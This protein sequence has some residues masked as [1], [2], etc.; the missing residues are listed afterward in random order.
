VTA[1][2]FRDL[3]AG[4]EPLLLAN[5]WDRGSA[6][7]LAALGFRALA[8]TSS[9]H[10]RS[11][12]RLD[13]TVTRDEAIAH[14]RDLALAVDVPLSA[15]LEDGFAPDPEGVAETVRRAAAA[16]IAGCSIE[17]ST[18]GGDEPV[19]E[20]GHAVERVAAAV[21]AAR[22]AGAD[23]VLTARAENHLYGR[24]DLDDTI[25]RLRAYRAAGADVVYAPGV[26]AADDIRAV[27]TAVDAPVNVLARPTTPPV[28]ELAA[29]GVRR[30]SVGGAFQLAALGALAEAG[31]ELL[32]RGTY[33]YLARADV[34][35]AA[36][37]PAYEG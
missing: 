29:L 13:G 20:L 16:G 19:Y 30:V 27:V 6:R 7:L 5:A 32:D 25:A 17:D 14:A 8:T 22:G 23:F 4:P 33:G 26:T 37:D 35:R 18:R 3:H 24:S 28:T 1:L 21:E 31:R 10:A 11:L 36:G 12:G 34:G 9:G 2:T 15:D